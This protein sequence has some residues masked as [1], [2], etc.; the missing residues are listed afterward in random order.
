MKQYKVRIAEDGRL[1]D[2]QILKLIKDKQAENVNLELYDKYAKGKN[3]EI[4]RKKD[5]KKIAVPYGRTLVR[6]TTGFMYK[7]GLI[8]YSLDSEGEDSLIED[9]LETFR[10]NKEGKLNTSIGRDQVVFGEGYELHYIDEEG[11]ENFARV[12]PMELIPLYSY[13]IKPRLLAAI[14]FYEVEDGDE[15]NMEIDVYYPDQI[16]KYIVKDG[17]LE[18]REPVQLHPYESVPVAVFR[19]DDNSM[20]DIEPVKDLIDAYDSLVSTYTDDEDKF[21]EAVLLLFGR[22]LDDEDMDKL[23]RLRVLDGLDKS[24]EDVRYLTKDESQST[25][26]HL[27]ELIR[28]EI[29]RQSFVPDLTNPAVLGQKSG[30]AFQYLFALFELMASVK[31][32]FFHD[33]IRDRIRL[34]IMGIYNPSGASKDPDSIKVEFAR[35]LPKDSVMWTD[36]VQRLWGMLPPEFLVPHIPFIDDAE[37]VLDKIEESKPSD[38]GMGKEEVINAYR[39][40]DAAV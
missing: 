18:E 12:S 14:R 32:S 39:G 24:E 28:S 21:A 22:S 38:I 40:Q 13:E 20:G 8:T 2:E 34:S 11:Q 35:N 6:I 37:S 9:L 1:T 15:K 16:E 17:K 4:T 29:Y 26:Q 3:Y 36:I 27:I 5:G 10:Y 7:P 19:N 30:E 31:E 25:R 23:D 33:G